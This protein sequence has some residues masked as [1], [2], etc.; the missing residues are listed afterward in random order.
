M[1][2]MANNKAQRR[3]DAVLETNLA[4]AIEAGLSSNRISCLPGGMAKARNT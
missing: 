1:N 2:P 4:V 3:I